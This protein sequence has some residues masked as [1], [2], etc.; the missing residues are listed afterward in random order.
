MHLCECLLW[1][2]KWSIIT[3]YS[4]ILLQ[5]SFLRFAYWLHLFFLIVT[6]R[7]LRSCALPTSKVIH[8]RHQVSAHC[9]LLLSFQVFLSSLS[10]ELAKKLTLFLFFFFSFCN[11]SGLWIWLLLQVF[12]STCS[13][14][15]LHVVFCSCHILIFTV[16]LRILTDQVCHTDCK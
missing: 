2:I 10:K 14:N 3:D 4:A 7:M 13:C 1:S 15:G 8:F 9:F 11:L 5:L 6:Y 12:N 16:F